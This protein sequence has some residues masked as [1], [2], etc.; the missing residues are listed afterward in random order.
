MNVRQQKTMNEFIHSYIADNGT[1]SEVIY[2][3][4]EP[5]TMVRHS[6]LVQELQELF[7]KLEAETKE[8]EKPKDP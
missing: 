4:G 2:V 6:T 5:I 3:F 1:K 8:P 7:W